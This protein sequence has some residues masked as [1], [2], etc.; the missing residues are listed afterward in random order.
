MARTAGEVTVMQVV[1]FDARADQGAEQLLQRVGAVVHALQKH[2]LRQEGDA[3]AGQAP[4]GGKGDGG[5]FLRMVGVDYD[6]DGG[7]HV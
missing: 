5:Q 1:G 2:G 4:E 6:E 3:G 7:A